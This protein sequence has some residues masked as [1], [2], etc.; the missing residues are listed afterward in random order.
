MSLG[1]TGEKKQNNKYG[2]N[3]LMNIFNKF[4]SGHQ[5]PS[6]VH[7]HQNSELGMMSHLGWECSSCSSE[8]CDMFIVVA[9]RVS[10]YQPINST[11]HDSLHVK[12]Q[13]QLR[14]SG[15]REKFQASYTVRRQVSRLQIV[16]R[17]RKLKPSLWYTGD[18]RKPIFGHKNMTT[19]FL[20]PVSQCNIGPNPKI[21]H[22][23]L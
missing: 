12:A 2:H 14:L 23:S 22:A 8:K 6:I 21:H 15:D 3:S 10:E 19:T 5:F 17:K 1:Y 7:L 18:H 11:I 16:R 9:S 4:L 13:K 20:E